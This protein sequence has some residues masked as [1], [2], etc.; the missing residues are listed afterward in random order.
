MS[1]ECTKCGKSS[2]A[3]PCESPKWVDEDGEEST[4]REGIN[5]KVNR[6]HKN[7]GEF[8]EKDKGGFLGS[9]FKYVPG[10]PFW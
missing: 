8:E 1:Y 10:D 5:E 9:G 6:V 3:C 4:Y 7:G 2:D